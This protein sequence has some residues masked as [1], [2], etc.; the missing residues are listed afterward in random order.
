M[1]A[2]ISEEAELPTTARS[3]L[4]IDRLIRH[5]SSYSESARKTRYRLKTHHA[6]EYY[7]TH[8]VCQT[9]QFSAEMV[10]RSRK[11]CRATAKPAG[12]LC[13]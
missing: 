9:W 4:G 3:V 6:R 13:R 2:Y 7:I 11:Y 5:G 8:C 12:R 10:T 1:N